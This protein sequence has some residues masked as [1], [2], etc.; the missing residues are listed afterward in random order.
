MKGLKKRELCILGLTLIVHL[1]FLCIAF[2][3]YR[4]QNTNANLQHIYERFTMAG[5]SPHYLYLAEN[6]YQ[7]EGEQAKLIVFYPLYPLVM[8]IVGVILLGNY[9]LAGLLISYVCSGLASIFMYRLVK[10]DYGEERA[11]ESVML[12]LMYPFMMFTMG[13]YT[14][15]LFLLLTLSGLYQI[16]KGAWEKAGI[17]GF[18]ASLCRM[19]GMLLLAPAVY[20][21]FQVRAE[22]GK[23]W[24]EY[25]NK[26]HLL[27]FLM[28]LGFLIYLLLNLV[29]AGK[30]N[31]FWDY[32]QAPP[33]YQSTHWI[34]ANMTKDYGMALD[35]KGL[36]YIIYWVQ[37]V[38]FFVAAF[39]LFYGI[40]KK[41]RSSIIVYGG[42]YTCFCYL[43][44]WLISGGRYMMGCVSLFVIFAAIEK[45]WVRHFIL[46][47]SA[48]LCMIYMIL[49][50]QGQAIM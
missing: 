43:T 21:Y 40:R 13:V 39:A 11:V 48:A 41:V 25:A 19:Q 16:R 33:W 12:F 32:Q 28:P 15:S 2:G 31:A 27:M 8:K 30:W 44:G 23:S 42:I 45:E 24:R 9:E 5:D 34:N 4:T 10:L 26:K 20:E 6:G 7:S 37:I 29:I 46:G 38:L 1:V 14:E 35:Y 36:N 18:F 3:V 50:M 47:I 22:E 17:L 49:Y